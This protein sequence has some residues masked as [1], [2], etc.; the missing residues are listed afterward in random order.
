M[1]AQRLDLWGT[2]ADEEVIVDGSVEQPVAAD[3]GDRC[4]KV[5]SSRACLGDGGRPLRFEVAVDGL[6]RN[7][8]ERDIFAI[9]I[10]ID[11]IPE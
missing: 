10:R 6:G 9:H 5:V 4:H 2:K 3:F 1:W 8:E 7:A 11:V